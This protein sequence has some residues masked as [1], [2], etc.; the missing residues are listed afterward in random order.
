[1][2][3]LHTQGLLQQAHAHRVSG[4]HLEVLGKQ[5]SSRWSS[6]ESKTL[7]D[8]VVETVKTAGLS[9]EQVK[10]VCEF[11]NTEAYLTEFKKEGSA[12]K[13]I[14]FGS[15]PADPSTVIKDLNDGGG[16]TVFDDGYHYE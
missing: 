1:M 5:A 7:S 14:D 12:H 2:A 9:P 16:G 8:A 10:R 6:G 11:A 15:G 3:D 4:E 13:F